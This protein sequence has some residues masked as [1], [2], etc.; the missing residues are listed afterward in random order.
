MQSRSK[1]NIPL[2]ECKPRLTRQHCSD[3]TLCCRAHESHSNSKFHLIKL[4]GPSP[5][6]THDQPTPSS[7]SLGA[8][9]S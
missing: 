4:H 2:S 9:V 8:Y 6:I 7:M 1:M 3:Y 5:G